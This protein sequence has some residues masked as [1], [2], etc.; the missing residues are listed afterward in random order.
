M[1][2]PRTMVRWVICTTDPPPGTVA[3]PTMCTPRGRIASL[4]DPRD[5]RD[6]AAMCK[7]VTYFPGYQ[8]GFVLVP[9]DPEIELAQALA[10]LEA[11]CGRIKLFEGVPLPLAALVARDE[12]YETVRGQAAYAIHVRRALDAAWSLSGGVASPQSLVERSETAGREATRRD[13]GRNA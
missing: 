9:G 1:V 2:D 10:E 3:V 8:A 6:Y 7:A 12:R 5:W 11:Q 4:D 13:P